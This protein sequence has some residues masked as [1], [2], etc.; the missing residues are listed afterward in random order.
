MRKTFSSR[1][2]CLPIKNEMTQNLLKIRPNVTILEQ[3]K[4]TENDIRKRYFLFTWKLSN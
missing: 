1:Q 4:S 2:V 3:H